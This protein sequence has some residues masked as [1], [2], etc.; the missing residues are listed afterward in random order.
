MSDIQ[1]IFREGCLVSLETSRWGSSP[2]KIPKEIMQKMGAKSK[3]ISG[4]KKLVDAEK[5]K[6]VNTPVH[7]ATTLLNAYALPFPIRGIHFVPRMLITKIDELFQ[8]CK[9]EFEEAV[10]EFAEE[11]DDYVEEAEEEL[12]PELFDRNQYPK[13]IRDH[14]SFTWRFF[15]LDIPS[16]E[17]GVLSPEQYKIELEKMRATVLNARDMAI[18]AL[19]S[20]LLNI[21]KGT[22]DKLRDGE[23]K[24]FHKSMITKFQEFFS[25]FADRNVFGDKKLA[26]LVEVCKE[27]MDGVEIEDIKKDEE[28][29]EEIAEELDEVKEV[30]E[31][32]LIRKPTRKIRKRF[33]VNNNKV[34]EGKIRVRIRVRR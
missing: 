23:A 9:E 10:E 2:R 8:Q 26:E 14:F 24:R 32:A 22:V 4:F 7:K 30:L 3:W 33:V 17:F 1:T 29:R 15:T 18:E 16:G 28:F 13:R 31:K 11:Y 6:P 19:R 12:G 34:P 25:T 21:V 20:Q 27:A 5:L